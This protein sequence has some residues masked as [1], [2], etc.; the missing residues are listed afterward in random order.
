MEKI[1]MEKKIINQIFAITTQCLLLGYLPTEK[2]K[3]MNLF[4]DVDVT[5]EEIIQLAKDN[6]LKWVYEHNNCYESVEEY[7]KSMSQSLAHYLSN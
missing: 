7:N 6:K 4:K 3:L 1:N 2:E 5:R